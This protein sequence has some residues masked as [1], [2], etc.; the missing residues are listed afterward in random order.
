MRI[1]TCP[2]RRGRPVVVGVCEA[3]EAGQAAVVSF[4][5]PLLLLPFLLSSADLV[6]RQGLPV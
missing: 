6:V 4:P 1:R 2:E 5:L 3:R